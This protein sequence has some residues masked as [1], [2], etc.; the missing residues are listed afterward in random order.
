MP[1]TIVVGMSGG[2][3]SAV[4]AW[5]LKEQGCDVIGVFMKNWEEEEDGVCTATADFDDVRRCCD[6]IGIPYYSVNFSR[7]YWDRVFEYF[8]SEYRLGRTPNPDV[9]CNREIKFK[10]LL[11]FAAKMGASKLATGHYA[12][13]DS[14]DGRYRLL[15]GTDLSKDQSYFLYLLGQEALSKALFPLGGILKKDVRAIASRAGLSV[16]QKKDSTGI[17][18]IGERRFKEFLQRYLPAQPGEMRSLD[19]TLMGRHDGLMYYTIGQRK[20]LGIGGRGTGEPW[21]VV[22]K[23]LEHNVLVIGQG[24]G[25]A[26]LYSTTCRVNELHFIAGEAPGQS[27]GCCAKIRYRQPDQQARVELDGG[28]GLITF[29]QPQRAITPGQAAVFYLGEECIGGGTIL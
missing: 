12:C 8:L 16:A 6:S 29:E 17:C 2:V 26:E 21:F 3:D 24:N 23:D 25:T 11:E 20:G 15:K 4:A 27:F 14:L 7:Q 1:D 5:L 10:E 19:G 9:L 18:F 28:E 22:S 13:I